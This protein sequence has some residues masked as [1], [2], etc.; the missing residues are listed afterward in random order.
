[1]GSGLLAR[2]EYV[3]A[4]LVAAAVVLAERLESLLPQVNH[5][6]SGAYIGDV[7][8]VDHVDELPTHTKQEVVAVVDDLAEE[9]AA[10]DLS[11]SNRRMMVKRTCAMLSRLH[12]GDV[13]DSRPMPDL[14]SEGEV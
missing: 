11:S 4:D 2:P 9:I 3:E 14:I 13:L 12:D 8:P 10:E 7:G 6:A 5:D 1:M